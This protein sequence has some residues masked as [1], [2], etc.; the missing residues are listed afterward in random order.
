MIVPDWPTNIAYHTTTPAEETAFYN[1]FYGPNGL[2]PYW[3]TNRT[4]AQMLDYEADVAMSHVASGSIYAHTFHI[5]NVRD[6]GSGKTLVTDWLAKVMQ[7]Y[8]AFY[9]VPL[10]SPDWPTLAHHGV[11]PNGARRAGRGRRDGGLRPGNRHHR[12]VLA[13][14]RDRDGHR[15]RGRP[16]TPRTAR[17][18][19]PPL[20]LTAGGVRHHPGEPAV[21]KVALVSEGTYPYAMGGVSVWCDQLMRGLSDYRWEMVALTVD[22]TERAVWR[23]PENLDRLVSI[24]LWGSGA[25]GPTQRPAPGVH[26][27]VRGLPHEPRHAA[28]PAAGPGGARPR[29]GSCGRW[30]RCTTTPPVAAT[31]P[32]P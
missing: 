8:T 20:T 25:G 28:G 5:A 23:F 29:A 4:Y 27:A 3:P 22:G 9:K 24:P 7:K 1:S 26:R 10:L 32:R 13:G 18:R 12:G 14:R 17:R 6:Y 11:Q 19:H 2:F 31:C 16:G 21:M 30:R 15:W